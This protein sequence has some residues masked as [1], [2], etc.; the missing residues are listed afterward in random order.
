M[1]LLFLGLGILFLQTVVAYSAYEDGVAIDNDEKIFSSG[2]KYEIPKNFRLRAP[3]SFQV[4]SNNKD[5]YL[6]LKSYNSIGSKKSERRIK[7]AIP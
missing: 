4:R 5:T 2:L 3:G 1:K 6:H 7:I